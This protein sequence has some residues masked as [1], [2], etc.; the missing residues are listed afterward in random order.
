MDLRCFLSFIM[1]ILLHL[2]TWGLLGIVY[3]LHL[4]A[5]KT[6]HKPAQY[7]TFRT[8][9]ATARIKIHSLR[10]TN[11]LTKAYKYAYRSEFQDYFSFL[12]FH[13][14]DNVLPNSVDSMWKAATVSHE[15]WTHEWPLFIT[16]K[17]IQLPTVPCPQLLALH[18]WQYRKYHA[19]LSPSIAEDKILATE[20]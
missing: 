10:F 7:V 20:L 8:T 12:F 15:W 11:S 1:P 4:S 18:W 19:T 16:D 13:F 3:H 2:A 5:S 14:L 6:H 9:A 17:F